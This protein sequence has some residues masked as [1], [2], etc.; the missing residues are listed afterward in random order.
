MQVLSSHFRDVKLLRPTRHADSRGF[1]SEAYSK[2]AYAEI[3]IVNEFVQDNHSLSRKKGVVRG[4]HFQIEP[5]AQAKLLRVLRGAV[6]D[7]VVDIRT[8]S[9]TYGQHIATVLSDEDWNQIFIPAGFAHGFCTMQEETEILYKVDHYYA[10]AHERGIRWNDPALGI[11][12]PI[13]K[14]EAELS[15][16]DKMLPLL[17]DLGEVCTFAGSA[18]AA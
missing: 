4:L 7:V 17:A 9:P 6:F 5:F 11:A 12:W 3:G 15:E 18:A 10:P 8:G 13:S 16:K 14:T 1:F 2:R